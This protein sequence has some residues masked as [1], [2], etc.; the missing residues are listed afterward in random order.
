LFG[1]SDNGRFLLTRWVRTLS[2]WDN[3]ASGV[4]NV[5]AGQRNTL[6]VS[7]IGRKIRL[8]VNGTLIGDLDE[9]KTFST[10]GN[11]GLHVD[12]GMEMAATRFVV[13]TP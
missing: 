11:F 6:R 2:G 9:T 5:N 10:F 13:T 8:E 3:M 12:G 4:A 1:I 7:A